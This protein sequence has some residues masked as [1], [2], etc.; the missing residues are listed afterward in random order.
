[1]K[2]DF[3]DVLTDLD[4]GELHR[5]LTEELAIV[6]AACRGTRKAGT[7]TLKISVKPEGEKMIV[8]GEVTT[9]VPKGATMATMFFASD[10][11]Q[12]TRDDPRQLPLKHVP[13]APENLRRLREEN[14][15]RK[16]EANE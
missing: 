1:M 10:D 12:L 15:E 11:G 5:Q 3:Q 4:S 2:R 8:G 6:V 7:L 14:A 13:K 9:K 16:A